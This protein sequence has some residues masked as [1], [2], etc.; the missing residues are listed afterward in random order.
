ML[1]ADFANMYL[2][3][4][5]LGGGCVQEEIRV[6]VT[7]PELLLGVLLAPAPMG[8][9][10][11]IL[12]AGSE[13]FSSHTGYGHT[14]TWGGRLVDDAEID[15]ET[16]ALD[17][18]VVAFDA[19]MFPFRD[20][21]SV[22]FSHSSITRELIKAHAAFAPWPVGDSSLPLPPIVTGNWGCG[23]FGGNKPLK[24]CIQLLACALAGRP[25]VYATFGDVPLSSS[26]R[27]LSTA[28]STSPTP[29]SPSL[30]SQ[31]LSSAPVPSTPTSPTVI[32]HILT[33]IDALP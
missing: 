30:F 2:G 27:S 19:L 31:W 15:P 14:T 10:E 3:G 6:G 32:D 26:L 1:Q 22:Q 16:G 23:A 7:S 17:T 29:I 11:T 33:Q 24:A 13:M 9:C 12:M 21:V 20:P 25:M 8:P 28:L 5:V 18:R 4:G